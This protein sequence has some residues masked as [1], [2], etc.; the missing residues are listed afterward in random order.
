MTE[1]TES[2]ENLGFHAAPAGSPPRDAA[3]GKTIGIQGVA[4]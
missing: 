2:S 3:F 4:A 1:P